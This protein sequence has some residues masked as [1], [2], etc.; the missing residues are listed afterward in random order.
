MPFEAVLVPTGFGGQ[1]EQ[2][3][4]QHG[5][6][7]EQDIGRLSPCVKD[8]AHDEQNDVAGFDISDAGYH[9]N[10]EWEKC[11]Q[12]NAP[13]LIK[14]NAQVVKLVDTRDLKSLGPYPSVS[15]RLRPRAPF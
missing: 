6:Q 15:V 13:P 10:I 1:R 3:I 11:K 9:Q 14:K 8:E 7:H 12:K 4:D 2:V 5:E